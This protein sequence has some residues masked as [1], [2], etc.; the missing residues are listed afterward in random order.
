[1]TRAV[2]NIQDGDDDV[3]CIPWFY[4][5]DVGGKGTPPAETKSR[6]LRV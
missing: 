5:F 3:F 1:M 6:V 4:S 2:P